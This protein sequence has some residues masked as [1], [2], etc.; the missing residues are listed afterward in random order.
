MD[1]PHPRGA[2]PL[3]VGVTQ[4]E[5]TQAELADAQQRLRS[6][7]WS[8]DTTFASYISPKDCAVIVEVGVVADSDRA[9]LARQ[10][11]GAV[12]VLTGWAPTRR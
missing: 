2:G 9:E 10:F 3:T 6:F 5:R 8:Q 11:G 7:V 4:C 12:M 1:R